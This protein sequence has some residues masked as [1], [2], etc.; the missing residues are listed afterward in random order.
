MEFYVFES[1]N[2]E[3]TEAI[4]AEVSYS[5]KK[6]KKN[7]QGEAYTV[8]YSEQPI[9]VSWLAYEY[10]FSLLSEDYEEE[11]VETLSEREVIEGWISF[12][13]PFIIES[14]EK[15]GIPDQPARRESFNDYVDALQKDGKLHEL[16]ADEIC[17]PDELETMPLYQAQNNFTKIRK[18]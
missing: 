15:D 17:I 4:E 8:F 7:K 6:L 5:S 14:F 16:I 2:S 9:N 18:M 13:L 3:L 11:E 12:Y 1:Y 10:G